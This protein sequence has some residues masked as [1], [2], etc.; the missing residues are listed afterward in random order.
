M[1]HFARDY[2]SPHRPRIGQRK[3]RLAACALARLL[4]RYLGRASLEIIEKAELLADSSASVDPLSVSAARIWSPAK[5]TWEVADFPTELDAP[6]EP[7]D[8]YAFGWVSK[9]T[10][11]DGWD[12]AFALVVGLYNCAFVVPASEMARAVRDVFGNPFRL[13]RLDAPCVSNTVTS[14]THA[15]YTDRAFDR[16]PILADALE[17]AGCTD[18]E[19][20][21]HCRGPGPHVRGCWVVDLVLGKE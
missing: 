12:A 10:E 14:L 20:L 4:G 18:A 13:G 19:I 16:L 7:S 11:K 9:V 2:T 15:I 8:Q 3:A 5:K 17:E 21:S 6:P 1:L